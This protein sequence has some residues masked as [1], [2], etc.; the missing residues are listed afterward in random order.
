MDSFY[1]LWNI[2]DQGL[3]EYET[4]ESEKL[5]GKTDDSRISES[6]TAEMVRTRLKNNYIN[7]TKTNNRLDT[8]G[9]K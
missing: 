8:C 3:K 7:T 2:L 1:L 5:W 4:K 9:T 6:E